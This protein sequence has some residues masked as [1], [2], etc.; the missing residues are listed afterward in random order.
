[1]FALITT[2]LIIFTVI[3][4]AAVSAPTI[5]EMNRRNEAEA[6][7]AHKARVDAHFKRVAPQNATFSINRA[8]LNR[9]ID[10][11]RLAMATGYGFT[12]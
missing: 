8:H 11:T 9:E 7:A 10:A 12:K 4:V 2:A 6:R 3:I 1:M 5:I